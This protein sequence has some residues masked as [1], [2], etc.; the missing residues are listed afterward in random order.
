[1]HSHVNMYIPPRLGHLSPSARAEQ[2]V[3]IGL[4]AHW[5]LGNIKGKGRS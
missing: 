2:C 3:A 1:M 4:V 5:S